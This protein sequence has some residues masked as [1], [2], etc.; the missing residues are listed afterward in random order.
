MGNPNWMSTTS[1]DHAPDLFEPAL[2]RTVV[3]DMHDMTKAIQESKMAGRIIWAL[4]YDWKKRLVTIE[5]LK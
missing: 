4:H 1:S 5:F 2:P 3:V